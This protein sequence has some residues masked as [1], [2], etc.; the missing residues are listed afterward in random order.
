ME[1][2]TTAGVV[3]CVLLTLICLFTGYQIGVRH[4]KRGRRA[5]QQ[6]LNAQSVVL[7]DARNE[8]K[9][10]TRFLAD[11]SRKDRLL[12]LALVKLKNSKAAITALQ[13]SRT[14]TD[15]EHFIEIARLKL[16]TLEAQQRTKQA[17]LIAK[18]ANFR[19]KV[20]EKA[21]PQLQTITAPEPKSYGQGEAV[22]VSVVDQPA[23]EA[24]QEQANAVTNR[25]LH[26][27]SSLEPSNEEVRERQNNTVSIHPAPTK[28]SGDNSVAQHE[29]SLD[30][31]E[32]A[33]QAT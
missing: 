13:K 6:A 26:R 29:Q 33:G 30:K 9:H 31:K 8:H 23:P 15:R 28:N 7:L 11:A 4:A 1:A 3:G 27:L 25:D 20:L 12:K 16:S 22:T 14:D 18:K 5:L 10:L 21:L 24:R 32:T 17:V 2:I 19:L